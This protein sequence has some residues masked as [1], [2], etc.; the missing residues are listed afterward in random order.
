LQKVRWYSC[1]ANNR[2]CLKVVLHRRL[3]RQRRHRRGDQDVIYEDQKVL[4]MVYI[5]QTDS[6]MFKVRNTTLQE[7]KDSLG[8]DSWTK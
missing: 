4:R 2:Y 7:W 3:Q 8:I 1:T 6:F 5:P